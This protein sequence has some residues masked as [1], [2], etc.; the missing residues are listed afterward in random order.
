MSEKVSTGKGF[1]VFSMLL[2]ILSCFYALTYTGYYTVK[3]L[4]A[5]T[6][7]DTYDYV[8]ATKDLIMEYGCYVFVVIAAVLSIIFSVTASN[9][10]SKSKMKNA[11]IVLS[12]I[13]LGVS[14]VIFLLLNL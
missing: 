10:G 4:V 14:T 11:G 2:G 7:P 12:A 8:Y 3:N 9:K 5:L 13:A 1:A 6:M